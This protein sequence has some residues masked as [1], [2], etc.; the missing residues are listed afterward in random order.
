MMWTDCSVSPPPTNFPLFLFLYDFYALFL[1]WSIR[2]D[3]AF[4]SLDLYH[5]F[6]SKRIVICDFVSWFA[7]RIKQSKRINV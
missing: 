1:F 4:L 2:G 5:F 6:A 7:F 3:N